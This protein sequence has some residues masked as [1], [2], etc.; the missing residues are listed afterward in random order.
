MNKNHTRINDA[1]VNNNSGESYRDNINLS[2]SSSK[3]PSVNIKLP[4]PPTVDLFHLVSKKSPDGRIP[5][6]SPNAFIIYRK[7]YVE[8]A[9]KSGYFLPMTNIS[10]MASQSWADERE[11]V[12]A[13]YQQIA[14]DALKVRN[15]IYP[16]SSKRKRKDRWNIVSFEDPPPIRKDVKERKKSK[17]KVQRKTKTSSQ[18][19]SNAT[20]SDELPSLDKTSDPTL[21][22]TPA[23]ANSDSIVNDITF[24]NKQN[25]NLD[26]INTSENHQ[27][28]AIFNSNINSNTDD[29]LQIPTSVQNALTHV[30]SAIYSMLMTFY[31]SPTNISNANNTNPAQNYTA[32][33]NTILSDNNN[34]ITSLNSSD[35]SFSEDII[36]YYAPPVSVQN[37]NLTQ[38]NPDEYSLDKDQ[39]N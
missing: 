32:Y 28:D 11:E 10:S 3:E 5:V 13:A 27:T 17:R 16:K 14:K 15:E 30:N 39:S 22:K 35:D 26:T 8:A 31:M 37:I 33:S 19:P 4:F 7:V 18:N 23:T 25:Q 1:L 12:R 34:E 2:G 36:H 24:L 38:L 21:H 20:L 9:R 29:V 6:R